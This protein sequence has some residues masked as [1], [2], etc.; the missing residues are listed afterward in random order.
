M[1]PCRINVHNFQ[2]KGTIKS[3]T[4]SVIKL[5]GSGAFKPSWIIGT[6]EIRIPWLGYLKL[7]VSA[8]SGYGV[9]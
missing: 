1:N 7:T 4:V 3:Q 5:P 9:G 2:R 6:A 8:M